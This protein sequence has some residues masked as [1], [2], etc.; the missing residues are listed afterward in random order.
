MAIQDYIHSLGPL[1]S[2]VDLEPVFQQNANSIYS[3]SDTTIIINCIIAL[4]MV[5]AIYEFEKG[6]IEDDEKDLFIMKSIGTSS[7]F[8]QQTMFSE[9][10]IIIILGTSIG[11]AISMIFV[12]TFLVQDIATPSLLI[13]LAFY[14]IFLGLF[15]V[16]AFFISRQLTKRY[17]TLSLVENIRD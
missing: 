16:L 11:L 1:F 10:S 5:V 4:V 15:L 8:I 3:M 7:K 12:V 2:G 6:R 9:Q 13:P 17:Y 14:V